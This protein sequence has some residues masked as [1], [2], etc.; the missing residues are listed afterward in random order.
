MVNRFNVFHKMPKRKQFKWLCFLTRLIKSFKSFSF[1]LTY[2]E[3]ESFKEL[4]Q[5]LIIL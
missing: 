5:M 4:K 1:F 2:F 3:S